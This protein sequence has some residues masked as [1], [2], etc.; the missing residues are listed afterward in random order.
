MYGHRKYRTE[1]CSH[2]STKGSTSMR[3][4]QC[5]CDCDG[6]QVWPHLM[7]SSPQQ[8]HPQGLLRMCPLNSRPKLPSLMLLCNLCLLPLHKHTHKHRLHLPRPQ[9]SL[10]ALLLRSHRSKWLLMPVTGKLISLPLFPSRLHPPPLKPLR[11]PLLSPPLLLLRPLPTP[12]LLCHSSNPTLVLGHN[13]SMLS[14]PAA[15]PLPLPQPAQNPSFSSGWTQAAQLTRTR[16]HSL[17]YRP[18]QV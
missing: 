18:R 12:P 14:S 10:S 7:L 13:P 5:A 11:Q 9:H 8:G 1:H 6:V 17:K 3:Q 4:I 16:K 2:L 15:S